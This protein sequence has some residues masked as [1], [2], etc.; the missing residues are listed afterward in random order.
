MRSPCSTETL[1]HVLAQVNRNVTPSTY[2]AIP[3]RCHDGDRFSQSSWPSIRRFRVA[4]AG[5]P[6][7]SFARTGE[8]QDQPPGT[9]GS[10]AQP[11]RRAPGRDYSRPPPRHRGI[12]SMRFPIASISLGESFEYLNPSM[13]TSVTFLNVFACRIQEC[14]TSGSVNKVRHVQI[15]RIVVSPLGHVVFLGHTVCLSEP[16]RMDRPEPVLSVDYAGPHVRRHVVVE[17]QNLPAVHALKS[18]IPDF[19]HIPIVRSA[20]RLVSFHIRNVTM[21]A[22]GDQPERYTSGARCDLLSI[23]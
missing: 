7:S 16:I 11:W 6:G 23:P 15:R 21:S 5:R 4:L 19:R 13:H 17:I 8:S 10:L 14:Y 18:G 3:V 2:K 12:A 1:R 22:G 20:L 9:P